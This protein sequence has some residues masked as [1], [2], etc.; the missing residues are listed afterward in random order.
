MVDRSKKELW[1]K[2]MKGNRDRLYKLR[3]PAE[4]E[5]VR[6]L[7]DNFPNTEILEQKVIR[8]RLFETRKIKSDWRPGFDRRRVT[9][10]RKKYIADI[11]LP[12]Y[13]MLIELDGG[14]H[15]SKGNYDTERDTLLM[16]RN[17]LVVRFPNDVV[18]RKPGAFL[19]VIK[20][21]MQDREKVLSSKI[22]EQNQSWATESGAST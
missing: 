10:G 11:Y 5:C 21:V 16:S 14:V 4:I 20:Q 17:F 8:I 2:S 19:G 15:R 6:I 18:L 3:T 9:I 1:A 12:A 7:K 22:A 13:K